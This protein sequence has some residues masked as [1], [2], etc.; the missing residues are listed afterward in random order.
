MGVLH[1]LE[2]GQPVLSG[3]NVRPHMVPVFLFN[4]V[5]VRVCPVLNNIIGPG[6]QLECPHHEGGAELADVHLIVVI[7][8]I[9]KISAIEFLVWFVSHEEVLCGADGDPDWGLHLPPDLTG[10]DARR[11]D[12]ILASDVTLLSLY[13]LHSH[14]SCLL[15]DWL[16]VNTWNI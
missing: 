4:L 10:P 14:V 12:E 5:P 13:P 1:F 8:N 16:T 2:D 9:G 3:L 11:V 15:M 6:L 7:T